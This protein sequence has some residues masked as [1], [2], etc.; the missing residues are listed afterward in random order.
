M[1]FHSMMIGYSAAVSSES[2]FGAIVLS[3]PNS[4]EIIGREHT[5]CP[6]TESWYDLIVAA[7]IE[8]NGIVFLPFQLQRRL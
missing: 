1:F 5:V 6:K 7:T 4:P 2:G 3:F 8:V